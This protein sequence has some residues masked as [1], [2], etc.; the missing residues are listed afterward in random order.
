MV[1][2]GLF[3][4]HSAD[5]VNDY[6]ALLNVTGNDLLQ[7]DVRAHSR[8]DRDRDLG[9]L[10]TSE[11]LLSQRSPIWPSR[12]LS[13]PAWSRGLLI[14]LRGV[15]SA[16]PPYVWI[17]RILQAAQPYGGKPAGKH[18]AAGAASRDAIKYHDDRDRG[19]VQR[20]STILYIGV[21]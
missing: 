9:K 5:Y 1:G 21:P 7:D 18:A 8:D 4:L 13:E 6:L 19:F 20:L 2:L 10:G 14:D 11:L 17:E 12:L 3:A 15:A 16:A